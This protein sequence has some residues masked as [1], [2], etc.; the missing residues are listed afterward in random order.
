MTSSKNWALYATNL[1][2]G[3]SREHRMAG[4]RIWRVGVSLTWT[5]FYGWEA[6][7]NVGRTAVSVTIRPGRHDPR[8]AEFLRTTFP[9]AALSRGMEDSDRGRLWRHREDGLGEPSSS[10]QP[11]DPV[12]P[13]GWEHDGTKWV[14]KSEG[15]FRDPYGYWRYTEPGKIG[16]RQKPDLGWE[17]INKPVA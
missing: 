12:Q 11:D 2:L 3:T 5:V 10:W 4:A 9:K 15:W 8:V 17:Y 13:E 1:R 7:M 14:R 6:A 16:W